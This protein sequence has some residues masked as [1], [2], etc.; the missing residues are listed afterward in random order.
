[1]RILTFTSLFPNK[2]EPVHG[3]FIAQ[4][5]SHLAKRPGCNVRVI[6][7]VPYFPSWLG[8]SRW[9]VAGQ[10]PRHESV[11]KLTVDHPRYPLLPKVSM[12]L[13]GFCMFLGSIWKA[14]KLNKEKKFDCIDAHYVYPDGF[15]AVLLGKTLDIPVIVS[16]RGTDV[17]LFPSFWLIRSLIRWTLKKVAGIIAVS[18]SLKE[19]IVTLGIP[20][21]RVRVIGNGI[22][23]MK[24][25]P[26]NPREAREHLGLPDT[27]P[28][29]VSVGSLIPRKGFQFLIPAFAQ[30]VSRFP[31]LNLYIIGEGKY[32]DELQA[33][34]RECQMQNQIHFVGNIPNIEL[35]LWYSAATL[36]CLV[37]SR[38]GWPNVLQESLACGTPVV[39]TRLWGAPEIVS[40]EELG[41][42]VEQNSRAIAAGL[43]KALSTRW[44]R[45]AIARHA[46][47]RTWEVVAEEV[48]GYLSS[49][50]SNWK[51]TA[52]VASDQKDGG[53]P[54]P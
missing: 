3:I 46:S 54:F 12:P 47:Q 43:E 51:R 42:L 16:A 25:S 29:V 41:I 21:N 34:S 5:I 36:S 4:R 37:S 7:P 27:G 44:D 2:I 50:I 18:A 30:I 38:E 19:V 11:E 48:E 45:A 23:P 49:S 32:G 10:I 17:N 13:Q 8:W 20:A 53:N 15:A 40:G 35:H 9:K 14:R 26:V 6:A 31:G 39:A 28:I 33:L 22:D 52:R 1:M 24:F